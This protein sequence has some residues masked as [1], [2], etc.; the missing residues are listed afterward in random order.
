MR[1]KTFLF[2]AEEAGTWEAETGVLLELTSSRPVQA[3]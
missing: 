1:L 2:I 3:A